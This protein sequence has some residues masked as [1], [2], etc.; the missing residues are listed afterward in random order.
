MA[1]KATPLHPPLDT[2]MAATARSQSPASG[3]FSPTS[4]VSYR[5]MKSDVANLIGDMSPRTPSRD[6]ST[7]PLS[8]QRTPRTPATP[9]TPNLDY[10]AQRVQEGLGQGR[11]GIDTTLLQGVVEEHRLLE[12]VLERHAAENERAAAALEK[13]TRDCNAFAAE[14]DEAKQACNTAIAE[15]NE[16]RRARD[17]AV[18]ELRDACRARDIALGERD[19]ARRVLDEANKASDEARQNASSRP[20]LDEIA[21]AQK[22][23]G[24][25]HKERD[26]ARKERD[27][28]RKERD[29]ARKERDRLQAEVEQLRVR[30]E[31]AQPNEK[32]MSVGALLQQITRRLGGVRVS[33]EV[34]PVEPEAAESAK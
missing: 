33:L 4:P 34:K 29:Q 15:R 26:D 9:P 8:A 28:A 17:Q 14:R 16:A 11:R 20:T 10:V 31:E 5:M 30:L 25:A 7:T 18:R 19:E 22:E 23:R 27:Q 32:D 12:T 3:P 1:Q 24:D 21:D 2:N 13:A 6:A